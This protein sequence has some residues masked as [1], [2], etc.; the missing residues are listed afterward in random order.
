MGS[1]P[2]SDKRA[3]K[4]KRRRKV[5]SV[6]KGEQWHRRQFHSP[7]FASSLL[8]VS[9][10]LFFWFLTCSFEFDSNSLCLDRL[11][12]FGIISLEKLQN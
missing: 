5:N 1:K 4:V 10:S 2:K 3:K 9:A 7:A 11:S 8:L 6:V 12:N